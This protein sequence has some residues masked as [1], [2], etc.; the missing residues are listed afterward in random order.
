MPIYIG[1]WQEMKLA[2][3][4][5]SC[6]RRQQIINTSR[7]SNHAN[8][9]HSDNPTKTHI[10]RSQRNTT[11]RCKSDTSTAAL[12]PKQKVNEPLIQKEDLREFGELNR[13]TKRDFHSKASVRCFESYDLRH[14]WN[15]DKNGTKYSS[16]IGRP[17]SCSTGK[18]DKMGKRRKT[19]SQQ[20]QIKRVN[21]M[22][23][24]YINP[25]ASEQL[26]GRNGSTVTECIKEH[27]PLPPEQIY[28]TSRSP[29]R[30]YL[31]TLDFVKSM[32]T[33]SDE[34]NSIENVD[35]LILW[36]DSLSFEGL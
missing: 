17:P 5:A 20:N 28:P 15:S 32:N 2:R 22:R 33:S 12:S 1:P 21:Q 7:Y 6:Q 9:E 31:T 8:A 35:Q 4:I 36:A 14:S 24:I 26:Y 16:G 10:K 18:K 30:E 19:Q 13:K 3:M 23:Q 25:S 29:S 34:K 27:C 11:I